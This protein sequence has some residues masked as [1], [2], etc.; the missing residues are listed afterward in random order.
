[1]LGCGG[2]HLEQVLLGDVVLAADD[3]LHDAG[4]HLEAQTSTYRQQV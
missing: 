4:Q 2:A 3:L 1:M